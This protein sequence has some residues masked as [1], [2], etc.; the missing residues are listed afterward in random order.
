MTMDCRNG[1]V[2]YGSLLIATQMS[3]WTGRGEHRQREPPHLERC[4]KGHPLFGP[5]SEAALSVKASVPA[6]MQFEAI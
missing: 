4:K 2:D 3:N 5:W 1:F 6:C